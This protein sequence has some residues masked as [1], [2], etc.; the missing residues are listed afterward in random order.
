VEERLAV[1]GGRLQ[2]HVARLE[3]ELAQA[4]RRIQD[5]DREGAA[6]ENALRASGQEA[7]ERRRQMAASS[8]DAEQRHGAE[9]SRLKG[10]M[11][12]L[13]RHL[14]AR[15]RAELQ[16]KK[17]LQEVERVAQARPAAPTAADPALVQ[18][19]KAKV[20][21]LSGEVE[22]LRGENDFLNGEVARYVQKNKDLAAQLAA[23]KET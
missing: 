11:V 16:L 12:E 13:E 3:Q 5:L 19:L 4:R 15:A 20:E 18:Q 14:E 1:E 6:R 22:E 2:A 7:E 23:L 9:V 8:A 17:K 21:K 10:A